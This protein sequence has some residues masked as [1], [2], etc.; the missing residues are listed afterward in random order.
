MSLEKLIA[1]ATCEGCQNNRPKGIKGGHIY[2]CGTPAC[3]GGVH[4]GHV[5]SCDSAVTPELMKKLRKYIKQ[6][7]K[8]ATRKYIAVSR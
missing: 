1:Q 7:I 2:W 3:F 4:P 6:R 5:R 8:R